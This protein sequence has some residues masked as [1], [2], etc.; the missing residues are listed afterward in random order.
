[1]E[2]CGAPGGPSLH[3]FGNEPFQKGTK[4]RMKR[5]LKFFLISV[6]EI[7]QTLYWE[8][9]KRKYLVM[10]R[11]HTPVE[12]AKARGRRIREGFFEKYCRDKGLDI[13]Y[14]GDLL[15][16]NCRGWDIEHGDAMYL[17]G[18]REEEFDFVYSSH[19][20]EHMANPG[21]AL[22]N[23]W[24]VLKPGGHLILYL[25]DRDLYEKRRRLPSRWNLDHKYFFLLDKD[26]LPDTLG[27][28]PLIERSLSDFE[29]VEAK[30]CNEGHTI[31]E[32]EKHSNGEYSLEVIVKKL[33]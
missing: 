16:D 11:P 23:W 21:V 30:E 24:R 1:V 4:Q 32:P 6:A 9:L 26:D 22:R 5:L 8:V 17:D 25:P 20:L 27:I 12:T 3:Q 31:T 28:I 19:T 15:T 33:G 18:I 29:V 7:M 10:G 14:G 13:G 2:E